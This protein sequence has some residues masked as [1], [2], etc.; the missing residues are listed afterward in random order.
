MSIGD[1]RKT[2]SDS[3]LKS[4]TKD[5]LI[6]IIRCLESN[7]RNVHETNDIQYENYKSLLSKEKN[8]TLDEVLHTYDV[9]CGL[10]SGDVK[11]LTRHVLMRVLDGL[12]E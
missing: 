7:L 1:E 10:Y 3:T 8:K 11:N 6:D 5:E 2:Y 4:M 12:R 9:K